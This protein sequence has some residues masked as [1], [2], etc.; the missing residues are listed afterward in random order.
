MAVVIENES[1]VI[2]CSGSDF[3]KMKSRLYE[4]IGN[5]FSSTKNRIV[6]PCAL[7]NQIKHLLEGI[8]IEETTPLVKYE[9]HAK[10]RNVAL[11]SLQN[12]NTTQILHPWTDTLDLPQQYAVSAM[13][14]PHLLGLCLF[15]EQGSG[16]TVMAIAAFDILR[17][18][19][20]IDLMIVISPKSMLN[21]W[22]GDILR[23]L[24]R[25]YSVRI[26]E[27][28]QEEKRK[29]VL[30][31]HDVIVVNYES[32]ASVLIPL[33]TIAKSNRVLL[34]VD[35]SYYAKNPDAYR[36]EALLQ[37]RPFCAKCFV[38]C[39]TP[40]PNSA[41]DLINQFNLA[42]L[43]Y[44]FAGFTKT[45][46][47][48]RD[49]EIIKQRIDERGTFIRRLKTEIL[50]SVPD[51]HFDVI[52]VPL[53]G[54]QKRMYQKARDSLVIELR[55]YDNNAFKRNLQ[56]YFQKR[57]ALLQICATPSVLDPTF[58]D[59]SAKIKALDKL[60]AGLFAQQRK[61][62][63]WTSY[64]ASV[65]ELRMRY[66]RFSPL[67]IDGSISSD[68]RGFAVEAF[69]TDPSRL[70]FIAN[71]SAAGAGITLHAAY[72]AVYFSYTNQAAHYLQS[73]DRI[74]RRGQNSQIVNYYL[75]VCSETIEEGE[76]TRLRA[77][78]LQQHELLGDH[79]VWPTSL[80]EALSELTSSEAES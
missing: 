77:R 59:D 31:K 48:S 53:E 65:Q 34:T 69:Q 58:V 22:E 12:A 54:R 27:G 44:T 38:L 43:G 32:V 1:L 76:V 23:F 28:T 56:S 3:I 2:T 51:K 74:H 46:N 60:L 70:L 10:A 6:V 72:D 20:A 75:F 50:K 80:D 21:G 68:D 7:Y 36:A 42:D 78:E 57:S 67:V 5:S 66:S 33:E 18:I 17:Q 63:V 61:V 47:K 41:Y 16:K 15:D 19:N 30:E 62:V 24:D 40:A 49:K 52:R 11:S 45:S 14:V 13:I 64:R 25:K 55:S 29:I 37:L 73:L 39:G 26:V 9:D 35:E 8:S 4:V 79:V 71:P